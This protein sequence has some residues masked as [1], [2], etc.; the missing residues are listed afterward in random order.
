MEDLQSAAYAKSPALLLSPHPARA[1]FAP[2]W[3]EA[4]PSPGEEHW[5]QEVFLHA[6]P[7]E[8]IENKVRFAAFLDA[9]GLPTT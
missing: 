6:G 4:R 1:D 5:A 7:E 3:E 2:P 9:G 8:R